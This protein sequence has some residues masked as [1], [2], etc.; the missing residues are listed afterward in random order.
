MRTT[1][2]R[3][4]GAIT[5]P[6]STAASRNASIQAWA[7][8]SILCCPNVG[9][10]KRI[11]DSGVA[12]PEQRERP[13]DPSGEREQEHREGDDADVC[14]CLRTHGFLDSWSGGIR[15]ATRLARKSSPVNTAG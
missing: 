7:N 1:P 8:P 6:A 10:E 5:M 15:F 12:R 9:E 3:A 14:E 4:A 2:S 13:G 11:R